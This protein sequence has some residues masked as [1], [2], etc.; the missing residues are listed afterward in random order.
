MPTLRL[1]KICFSWIIILILSIGIPNVLLA[2][3]SLRVSTADQ[4]FEAII[5]DFIQNRELDDPDF[6]FNT[7]L[8]HLEVLQ[9]KPLVLNRVSK[10]DLQDLELLS[11]VQITA[12]LNYRK[13]V[14]DLITIYELQAV[15]YFDLA[16]I[17]RILPFV[18]IRGG[19]DDFNV[20]IGEMLYEGKNEIFVRWQRILEERKGFTPLEEGETGSRYLGDPNKLYFRYRHQYYNRLSFGL[21]AEKDDGEEFFAG[22]NPQGF[23]FYSAHLFLKDYNKTIKSIAIGDYAI[24]FGQGLILYSGFGRGKGAFAL[25]MKRG[26]RTLRPY[27]SVN[28]TN[29]LRGAAAT[30][31][32][33]ENLELT[34]FGSIIKRDGNII[35]TDTTDL[36]EAINATFSS[37]QTTG[38]HRTP[39]EIEDEA[40]IQNISFG[41]SLKYKRDN[42]HIAL[43]ALS[44]NFDRKL[45]RANQLYNKFLFQGDQLTN[46]SLDYGYVYKN[47][48]FFGETARSDNGAIATTN[49][50][51]IGLDR[52]V[53]VGILYRD[54]ARDYQVINANP[55]AETINGFNERGLYIGTEIKWDRNWSASAYFDT[56]KH[57]W[58]RFG[59]DAP[60][61]GYEYLVRI[62]YFRKR[63]SNV[64]FQLRSE[65]KERNL[66]NNE[67]RLDILRPQ[68]R[69]Q[70]RLHF[71]NIISKSLEL[72]NRADLTY[73]DDQVN[74][75]SSGY[76][77]LQDIIFKPTSFPISI[78]TRF[79]IFD[80]PNYNTRIYAFENDLL[81][82]FSVPAFYLR[83]TRFYLNLRYKGI[84]KMTI[85]VRYAQTKWT[86]LE[87]LTFFDGTSESLS[88]GLN[89]IDGNT[90]S[91]VKCQIKYSF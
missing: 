66:S 86:D 50:L 44:N 17:Q 51:L 84:R 58:L 77:V 11:D 34:A 18:R 33:A 64:Y 55:F 69:T 89:Q 62:D 43:N 52:K 83:G 85:E 19:L 23:D 48:N 37:L 81:N 56:W 36:E 20:S 31:R 35:S 1:P 73:F 49:G 59:V 61:T 14:G 82:S 38:F 79:A 42:W 70:F 72:R 25:N 4:N 76:M 63:K 7:L 47:Y 10:E 15:P 29:F 21:T 24:S 46:V 8:E 13:E 28:E 57:P 88:S 26:G 71:S 78:T 3:D 60:S 54:F 53:S 30:I 65:T 75:Q 45:T 67:T 5:E 40:S 90:R 9:E 39:N 12:F 91:E 32:V 16:T 22:S 80:T 74:P 87:T 68:R 6:D 2:Q 27:T 41:G